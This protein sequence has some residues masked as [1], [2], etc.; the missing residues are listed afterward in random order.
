MEGEQGGIRQAG[1]FKPRQT[2][3]FAYA[4]D[5]FADRGGEFELEVGQ[6]LFR[7]VGVD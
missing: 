4:F 1:R 2:G 6:V 3:D 5:P 7:Q